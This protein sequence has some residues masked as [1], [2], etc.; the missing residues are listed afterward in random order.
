VGGKINSTRHAAGDIIF[1]ARELVWLAGLPQ[2]PGGFNSLKFFFILNF[3]LS[4]FTP[5]VILL[6]VVCFCPFA[7]EEDGDKEEVVFS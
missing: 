5:L 7:K 1:G 2:T 6:I 4:L 3:R